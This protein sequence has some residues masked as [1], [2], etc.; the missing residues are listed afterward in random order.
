MVMGYSV[1]AWVADYLMLVMV[2]YYY[3]NSRLNVGEKCSE[4]G[5]KVD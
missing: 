1:I 4:F 5:R 3:I 2:G